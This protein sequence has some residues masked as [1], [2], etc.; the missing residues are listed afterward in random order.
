MANKS[1][2]SESSLGDLIKSLVC[3]FAAGEVAALVLLYHGYNSSDVIFGASLALTRAFVCAICWFSCCIAEALA[4][5]SA[6]E[7][8]SDILISLVVT[9]IF[10]RDGEFLVAQ[11]QLGSILHLLVPIAVALIIAAAFSYYI[12]WIISFVFGWTPFK[13]RD[14]SGS[15]ESTK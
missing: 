13:K 2:K 14:K 12:T 3:A 15:G 5:S 7:A 8:L 9:L 4:G 10:V 1:G 11:N 6:K